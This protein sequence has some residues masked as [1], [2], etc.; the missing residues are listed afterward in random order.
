MIPSMVANRGKLH[1]WFILL[2]VAIQSASLAVAAEPTWTAAD[3]EFFEKNVRP[4]LVDNCYACHSAETKA[5]G[6]LR[7]DDRN[8]LLE[9]GDSGPAVVPGSP[10]ESLLLLAVRYDE[11]L[12]MPPKKQLSQ[13]HIAVLETWIQRGAAW[14]ASDV[15]KQQRGNDAEYER[16]RKEH[17]AWQPL[18]KPAVPQVQNSQWPAS[19]I[20]RFVLSK[21]EEAGLRPG[22][23]A[24]KRALL[25]RVTFD[26]TGLPPTVS[27]VAEFLSDDSPN[28]LEKVVDRLL[29]ST[30]Y[31]ER[32]GRH[33][34][35]V[36]R[37]GE[38]TGS[39]RNLPYP[40]AWRYRDYVISSFNNDKPY[41]RFV[42]EQ[43]AG[44]L[45]PYADEEQRRELLVA[46]GFLAI[47]VKDVNQ[48][49]KVRYE[50]DNIDEQID[51]VSRAILGLTVSCARCHDH[52]YDPIPTK[53]YYALA[54]IFKS[55]DLCDALRN[56][57]GGSGLAYYD[58]SKLLLLKDIPADPKREK[59][60]E[61]VRASLQKAQAELVELRDDPALKAGKQREQ[62]L[63]AARRKVNQVER[64]LAEL[65]DP[66]V[67]TDV[68]MG[69]RE[70]K[71]IGDT[72]IRI[73]GEAEKLG[74]TVPR[75]FLSVIP[76]EG[77][78]S[79]NPEQ[80][81]R[82]E[83]AKWLTSEKNPLAS[84]VI[85][86][87][88]WSHLFGSGLVASVDNFGVNGDTPSHPELLDYLAQRLIDHK[89]SLKSLIRDIV[90]SRTYQ[91]SA[92]SIESNYAVD[93][94]NRLLWRHS[95]RRLD[96][97]EIRDTLLA[98]SGNLIVSPP[99]GSP[100]KNFKVIELRGNQPE[101][102]GL[103][104]FA[105]ESKHR[106]VYLPLFRTLTPTALEVFDFAD[107][108]LVTGQRDTTTVSPQ[109]LFLLNDP[110]VVNQSY[111]LARR[112]VEQAELTD[113]QRINL[114]FELLLGRTADSWEVDRI[115]SYL[116][117]IESVAVSVASTVEPIAYQTEVEVVA[118]EDTSQADQGA[119]DVADQEA[120]AV[121]F[122][123][124]VETDP[125]I[126]VWASIC[127]ALYGSAEFR[128][129]Q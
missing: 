19:D 69:V 4:I 51:T 27:E 95:P 48:R 111:F 17:W 8:G 6:G 121:E 84:R 21:L 63:R 28:A 125:Q 13:E 86:N 105:F 110:F 101:A 112:L 24:E 29:A 118:V 87:R 43:I 44:D 50:M 100:A 102:L 115:Q 82:L 97:E 81:G 30:A 64:R 36:A 55:T 31:G 68:A 41:D 33:W 54:G 106:S 93:P 107:Q 46:T 52:K 15:P 108:A 53:D 109:A 35:D 129:L 20:D 122:D 60:I 23:D 98:S 26:L 75:G 74:P 37:Y 45:L 12:E 66:A 32:W 61:K 85:V 71:V 78:E 92:D 83:L 128:Y 114:A 124:I 47:G 49:F 80:S 79:I 62:K 39:A 70:A 2:T 38:S 67:R 7:V 99:Q 25:R 65:T 96:A 57:M 56:R 104:K 22:N 73:R 5:N 72:Q 11:G 117:T 103:F 119:D 40:H 126:I 58:T 127:Q 94:T 113:A 91:L 59:E 76:I 18:A 88:V 14:P 10:S 42:Q 120:P 116:R 77:L 34:L 89:W 3:I 16:L 123:R 1:R 90:L 9:G